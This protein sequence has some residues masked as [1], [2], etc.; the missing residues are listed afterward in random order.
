LQDDFSIKITG[1]KIRNLFIPLLLLTSPLFSPAQAWKW[2]KSIGAPNTVASVKTIR[3]YKGTSVLVSGSFAAS[4]LTLG[5][6]T[7]NSAGQ[8]DGYLAIADEAGAYLWATR[9]GGSG[10]DFV[11]DAAAAADGSFV[12]AGNFTSI[13]LNIGGTT[14]SNSGETDAFI[15]KY[16]ADKTI[17]WVK[18]IGTA[19]LDEVNNLIV[20][21]DGNIYLSG[22]VSDKFTLSTKYI[23]LRKL[24]NIGNLVWEEKGIMQG[25]LL[26]ANALADDADGAIY[27]G[28]SLFGTAAFGGVNLSSSDSTTAAFVVKYAP[29]GSL[30]DNFVQHNLDRVNALA[31]DGNHLYLGAEKNGWC[32]GW[33]WPLNESKIHLLKLDASLNLVWQKEAGGENYCQ[34]LDVAKSISVDNG[35]NVYVTGF[36]F[37]DTLQFA[38]QPLLN[39]FNSPYYYPEV[40]VLKYAPD[41]NEIWGKLLGGIHADEATCIHVA[42][43]DTFFLGGNFESDPAIF[44]AH[45]LRNTGTLDSIY[46]HLMP[47]RYGRKPMGFLALFDKETSGT[48]PE[49]ALEEVLIFPNPANDQLTVRL[50]SPAT[51]P[52]TFQ[53]AA[54]DGRLLRKTDYPKQVSEISEDLAGLPPGIYFITLK[55]GEGLFAGR[56]VKI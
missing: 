30:V 34:S 6:H 52:L 33:G 26:Q 54:A 46:V 53:L 38:G 47:A 56:V 17:A 22:Q 5:S 48:T 20:D 7:L 50:K 45:H 1:M 10:R 23:F 39:P 44:G 2:A 4:N 43:D 28:G 21:K 29:S 9:F 19:D 24:D 36:I 31:T 55:T 8:D 11:A 27:L 32:I 35:G 42:G 13:S 41:G 49:P 12:V 3:P 14:L 25:G 51:S 40:F 16:S 18:K 37:S 15:A